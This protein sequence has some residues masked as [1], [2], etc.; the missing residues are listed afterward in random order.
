M[1]CS[2]LTTEEDIKFALE[3]ISRHADNV[4]AKVKSGAVGAAKEALRKTNSRA[5]MMVEAESVGMVKQDR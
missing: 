2:R 3:V 1:V 5:E 4:L